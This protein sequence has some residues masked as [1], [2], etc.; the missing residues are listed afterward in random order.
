MSSSRVSSKVSSRV[1]SYIVWGSNTNVGKS[2]VSSALS[3]AASKLGVPVCYI[4]PIQTGITGEAWEMDGT[5]VAH[6]LGAAHN[7]LPHAARAAADAM[8]STTKTNHASHQSPPP[9]PPPPSPSSSSKPPPPSRTITLLP[10]RVS[11]LFGW[12][13]PVSPHLAVEME[14]RGV[15][16]EE[17]VR[18]IEHEHSCFQDEIAR[19]DRPGLVLIEIA[20]GPLSPGPSGTLFA[21]L[22]RPFRFPGL[23][24]G[25][26]ELGGI[27]GTLCAKE[28]IEIRGFD[29][30]HLLL[31]ED[32]KRTGTL[33]NAEA[34]GS[35]SSPLR[36]RSVLPIDSTSSASD[37]QVYIDELDHWVESVSKDMEQLVVEL[38]DGHFEKVLA[39]ERYPEEALQ[40]FWYPFAQH[41]GLS[42]DQVTLID[43][44]EGDSFSVYDRSKASF[45]P[46]FD[47]CASWWT[48]GPDLSMQIEMGKKVGYA[49]SRY[50]HVIFPTNVHEPVL[51]CTRNLLTGP[52]MGWAQ[53]VFYSDNGSTAIEVALKMAFRKYLSDSLGGKGLEDEDMCDFDE[54]LVV[55]QRGA[56]HG[57]TLA[58]MNAVEK[59]IFNGWAQFPWNVQKCVAVQPAYIQQKNGKFLIDM[60]D[61]TSKATPFKSV[62]DY[63]DKRR[64]DTQ[65]Q[66]LYRRGIEAEL[67]EHSNLGALLIEPVCQG[68]GGMKFIDPLWQRELVHY[69][70]ERGIPVIYDEIFVGLWRCGV[71]ST[72]D[73]LAIDP[74]VACY[75]KLLTGGAVPLAVTLATEEVF[76]CFLDDKKKNALLH[77]HSYTAHP[78]GCAAANVA[79]GR[80]NAILKEEGKEGVPSKCSYYWDEALTRR[81]SELDSVKSAVSLGTVLSIELLGEEGYSS[82]ATAEIVGDLGEKGIYCRPLGNV[83]Y[84]MCSPFTPH[85]ECKHLLET[86]SSVIFD[87][88][89]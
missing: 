40:S 73:L 45:E 50:G 29:L 65:L 2:L 16:D 67:E 87:C 34:L 30:S 88:N 49:A 33:N 64:A 8:P 53:R 58:C 81:I 32:G 60:P 20:G 6:S 48:Q 15:S 79:F 28:S 12:K 14:G 4:K 7:I 38:L 82:T 36:V 80:Y 27:S 41:K 22:L 84:F 5:K 24:V 69:C 86:L 9:P 85:T 39:M 62:T 35:H 17:I 25:S 1:A 43:S 83:L 54:L 61:G 72:K 11:T 68:A 47:S 55:T 42:A 26:A 21:D 31:L 89:A 44:R 10:S 78:V 71:E 70:R 46:K 59:S 57:D 3:A 66:S 75:A 13:N 37:G 52:G 51:E 23:L 63:F 56:Y 18:A 19:S 76:D 74:D 77:G